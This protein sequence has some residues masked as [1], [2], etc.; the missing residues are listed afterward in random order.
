MGVAGPGAHGGC[1]VLRV[2][3]ARA[4]QQAARLLPRT[5]AAGWASAHVRALWLLQTSLYFRR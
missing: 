4:V 5:S 2:R 3:A 1:G